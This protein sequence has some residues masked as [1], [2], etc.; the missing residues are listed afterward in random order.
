[1]RTSRRM[2]AERRARLV[3]DLAALVDAAV[4]VL[5]RC[6]SAARC[7]STIS[8]SSGSASRAARST[9]LRS[10][11]HS[12]VEAMSSSSS[13][14][15]MPPRAA[16]S[17]SGRTSWAPPRPVRGFICEEP[18][19]LRRLAL[20]PHDLAVARSRARGRAP[21]PA[22]P[23]TTCGAPASRG[24]CRTPASAVR[25]RPCAAVYRPAWS[26]GAGERR[27]ERRGDAGATGSK[28]PDAPR[29]TRPGRC[30]RVRGIR[31]APTRPRELPVR[32][33]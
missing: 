28:L 32:R 13:G 31:R 22:R 26:V 6:A 29:Q 11:A 12:S 27:S 23:R 18:A 8:A 2:R 1:M 33:P 17:A 16:F 14:S 9:Y 3:R 30:R 4:D 25:A 24:S 19:R 20:A 10:R 15:R 5:D 21:A 7:T